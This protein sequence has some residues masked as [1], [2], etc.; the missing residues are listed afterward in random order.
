VRDFNNL[1]SGETQG[2]QTLLLH[3][4]ETLKKPAKKQPTHAV[5]SAV[6]VNQSFLGRRILLQ[7][8]EKERK[9]RD[10][11]GTRFFEAGFSDAHNT[12]F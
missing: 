9:G 5:Q 6:K 8:K 7:L 4:S 11:N 3:S 1:F 10:P 12:P 2:P